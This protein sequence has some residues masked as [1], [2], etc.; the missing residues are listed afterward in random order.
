MSYEEY[1]NLV[2]NQEEI[3]I[4]YEPEPDD[5]KK[6]LRDV[7]KIKPDKFNKIQANL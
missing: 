4:V 7:M 3:D 5:Y 6:I 1:D 2:Q